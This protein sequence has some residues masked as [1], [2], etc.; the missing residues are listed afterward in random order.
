MRGIEV[1]RMQRARRRRR[2]ALV[3]DAYRAL[4]QCLA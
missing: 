2:D 1:R 3:R 4:K